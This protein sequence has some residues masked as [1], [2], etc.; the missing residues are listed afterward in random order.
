[1]ENKNTLICTKETIA[2]LKNASLRKS[3]TTMLTA[4]K[5]SRTALWKYAKAV[6]DI[7]KG[8]T[9]VDDFETQTAFAKFADLSKS[10][11]TNY[12]KAVEFV[13][14][15][16]IKEYFGEELSNLS[17][18]KAYILSTLEAEDL[19]DFMDFAKTETLDIINI[20]D[21]ALKDILRELY[22]ESEHAEDAEKNKA[23]E[24]SESTAQEEP[25]SAESTEST[26]T[27]EKEALSA[28]TIRAT[29]DST[30]KNIILTI[31]GNTFTKE[32]IIALDD[33]VLEVIKADFGG[34]K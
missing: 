5:S 32:R 10:T 26:E 15:E 11:I 17:V 21:R 25:D 16:D 34:N 33:D 18:G 30:G 1:M 29:F 23:V 6:A 9:F 13:E 22:Y 7:I 31:N 3:L 27:T 19:K 12:V 2:N 14:R 24:A 8:E 4:S 28:P 20:S